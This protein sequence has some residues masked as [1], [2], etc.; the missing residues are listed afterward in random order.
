MTVS[1]DEHRS[2]QTKNA[3]SRP[4]RP[5]IPRQADH[6]F[7]AMPFRF[8]E[9]ADRICA[10]AVRSVTDRRLGKDGFQLW[11]LD[12]LQPTRLDML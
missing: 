8:P 5:R 4:N 9:Q 11:P 10:T 3:Y 1:S 6:G 2:T 7:H 12:E